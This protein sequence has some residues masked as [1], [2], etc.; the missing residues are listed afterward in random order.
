MKVP[1]LL[2]ATLCISCAR[3]PRLIDAPDARCGEPCYTGTKSHA[4]KGICGFGVWTCVGDD[5]TCKGSGTPK[6]A[7]CNGLDNNCD[8]KIDAPAEPCDNPCGKGQRA[9]VNGILSIQCIGNEGAAEKCD[10]IDNDCDGAVDDVT[11]TSISDAVCYSA[12]VD[13]LGKGECKAGTKVCE[14]GR[15]FCRGE[16]LPK[17]EQCNHKDD[18]CNGTVDDGTAQYPRDIVICIDNSGSM[19]GVIHKIKAVTQKWSAK[20]QNRADLAW[21]LEECPAPQAQH[22]KAVLVHQNFGNVALLNLSVSQTFAGNT[23]SEPTIDAVY[24]TALSTN[25]LSLNWRAGAKR[26]FIMFTDEV[27]QSYLIPQI[28]AEGAGNAAQIS[29]M[30]TFIFTGTD[31]TI[32]N[33]YAPI[34]ILSGGKTLDIAMDPEA[35]ETELDS[36]ID[37]CP[38]H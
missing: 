12:S 13:T 37:E 31:P 15:E 34:G 20:Y 16:V 9:C 18:N 5:I 32:Y 21:A 1:L 36:I 33:S 28:T 10:G 27:A 17:S 30:K 26:T 23:G 19:G 35:M 8:G 24:L 6:A 14:N 38:Q 29:G 22:D 25:P 3:Q 2:L 7:T 4:G 11:Y